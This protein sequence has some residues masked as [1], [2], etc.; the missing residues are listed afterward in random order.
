V[1]NL[2]QEL[3]NDIRSA[4]FEAN[5]PSIRDSLTGTQRNISVMREAFDGDLKTILSEQEKMAE[6]VKQR[7]KNRQSDQRTFIEDPFGPAAV[8][9][10]SFRSTNSLLFREMVKFVHS[11]F[12]VPVY[13]TPRLHMQ[14]L[15]G[16]CQQQ[17]DN[18]EKCCGSLMVTGRRN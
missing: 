8:K 3:N 5:L 16:L 13:N 6:K 1:H 4:T 17:P 7:S 15:A 12:S 2:S 11:D 18:Q 14:D 10:V 9:S